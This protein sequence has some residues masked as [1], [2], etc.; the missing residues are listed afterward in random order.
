MM[1]KKLIVKMV[2]FFLLVVFV[3]AVGFATAI[4]KMDQIASDAKNLKENEL[5]RYNNIN[6]IQYNAAV[7]VAAIRGYILTGDRAFADQYQKAAD[8]NSKLEEHLI[9]IARSEDGRK[10][11][12]DLKALDDKYSQ[13]AEKKVF[14]L[15]QAGKTAEALAANNENIET[16]RQLLIKVAEYEKR[17]AKQTD[18]SITNIAS[19]SASGEKIAFLAA[20]ISAVLGI[21]IGYYSA[22]KIAGSV[23]AINTVAQK[24]ANGD[25]TDKVEITTQ[26]EIGQLAAA[27][28]TMVANLRNLL[29]HI[30]QQSELVAA[31]SQELTA[32]A[33]QSAQ[34]SNLVANSIT[35]VANQTDDQMAA[36]SKASGIS[37]NIVA[38]LEE[39]SANVSLV[40]ERA[41]KAADTASEGGKSALAAI[42]QMDRVEKTVNDSA[43]V[44]ENLSER[45]KEIGEI[46]GAISGIASQTNLLAL[47]AAIEAARAGE[48]GRGFAVVAEEVRKLAEQSQEAAKH[49]ADLIGE[50]QSETE[51]AMEAMHNGTR[52]VKAGAQVVHQTGASFEEIV[53]LV[54]G[55]SGQV[56][57]I[58][59][60]VQNV[61]KGSED[62]LESVQQVNKLC[63]NSSGE[64]QNVSAATEEQSASMEEIASASQ[65]LAKMAQEMQEAVGK[66]KI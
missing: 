50:I 48:Q 14:P 9:K 59:A 42:A 46:V 2:S 23:N 66:F 27:T 3:G 58:S 6:D 35:N 10:I 57:D 37:E 13:V 8:E 47:N 61:A 11:L 40:A 21:A 39:V 63:E 56:K 17:I 52:E 62:I 18:D 29:Q 7:Q 60:N 1:N 28:N 41:Q 38:E 4:Y 65:N 5:P 55:V 32:S 20:F 44:V 26:D 49:I 22:R 51:K 36:V 15:V 16:G 30:G 24:V 34:A 53:K 64:I 31:S 19:S 12:A 45:S 43:K 33:D 54:G 25:L